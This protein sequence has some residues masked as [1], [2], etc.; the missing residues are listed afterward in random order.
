MG[1]HPSIS[2]AIPGYNEEA[3]VP[4]LIR[5]TTA[6]LDG[7]PGG[8]RPE[9]GRLL[10]AIET[11]VQQA[12]SQSLYGVLV[13]A[14][15]GKARALHGAGVKAQ[16]SAISATILLAGVWA[17]FQLGRW[18]GRPMLQTIVSRRAD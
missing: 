11:A 10:S 9:A 12:P 17:G 3:V 6:V 16:T 13:A 5:R 4:E 2:L 14:S 15:A 18:T 1:E 7:V 8:P